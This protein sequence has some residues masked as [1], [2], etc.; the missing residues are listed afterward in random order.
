[1][2][3]KVNDRPLEIFDGATLGD[4]LSK[5]G[6]D[7]PGIAVAVDNNVVPATSRDAFVLREGNSVLI[8]G[9]VCG[10]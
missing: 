5:L 1:M 10:G 9:A 8:I 4:L 6:I 7:R 3:I 2:N